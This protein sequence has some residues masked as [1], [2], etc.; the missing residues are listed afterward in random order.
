MTGLLK[1]QKVCTT[2]KLRVF[3]NSCITG[4]GITKLKGN[5]SSLSKLP[6]RKQVIERHENRN[7]RNPSDFPTKVEGHFNDM[8]A[9]LA[10]DIEISQLTATGAT[11]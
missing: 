6:N 9:K 5:G 10:A 2:H 7:F 3:T 11:Q 1:T 4:L 8:I